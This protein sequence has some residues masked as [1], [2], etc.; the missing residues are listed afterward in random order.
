[1]F[2][3][4]IQRKT[5][6]RSSRA[7]PTI[8]GMN[9]RPSSPV[10]AAGHADHGQSI[11]HGIRMRDVLAAPSPDDDPR[12]I[13]IPVS[14]A[15]DAA[16][17]LAALCTEM[18]TPPRP[19]R[20]RAARP[21]PF[22]HRIDAVMAADRWIAPLDEAA[23]RE[24]LHETL[25]A[26]LHTMLRDRRGAAGVS[27]W[28]GQED[29]L[30]PPSFL[31]N[32]PAFYTRTDGLDVA[33][34]GQAVSD[35]VLALTLAVPSARRLAVAP[36]GLAAL[37]DKAG[38]AYASQ[39]AQDT[40]RCLT[41]FIR[42]CADH[43]SAIMARSLGG[44][45][46][47]SSV[48]SRNL[49]ASCP[50]PGLAEAARQAC[51]TAPLGGLRHRATTAI[52][53][54]QIVE[55][56]L[57]VRISGIAPGFSP[58]TSEGTLSESAQDW[59]LA[60]GLRAEDAIAALIRGESVFP[61]ADTAARIAMH[62][63]VAPFIH[64]MEARPAAEPD[65]D[66]ATTP[67]RS[68]QAEDLPARRRGYT[69]RATVGG[70]TVFLRTGEYADGRLGEISISLPKDSPT[71]RGLT[72]C[73]AQ[74]ISIGL[75]H[76]VRLDR[77]VEA[78]ALT[79]FGPAGTVEGDPS[80]DRATSIPDYVVRHLAA[81][82][83]HQAVTPAPMVEGQNEDEDTIAPLLPLDL[84]HDVRKVPARSRRRGLRLVNG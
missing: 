70:H 82:Y 60:R 25:G 52:L 16:A 79:D 83:T 66:A 20:G 12:A 75:Q 76:G 38:L 41:A 61:S 4:V 30:T 46:A 7:G 59:L 1:M 69:Q 54:P 13:R 51:E 71:A 47:A 57:G 24:G 49:P 9:K 53:P 42:A 21:T 3:P 55:S 34:L 8:T 29:A 15:D 31:I 63:A 35:A 2:I 39:E 80:V 43:A 64:M 17:A 10:P 78:L 74:A 68:A 37:F 40:A 19:K 81:S 84:P 26:S 56:L 18:A 6:S 5:D 33:A 22:G 72:E 44:G 77:F 48:V 36:T 27:L 14:W 73:L 28:T 23:C 67:I 11:W 32:L 58:L 45:E 65:K 50:L 62:D